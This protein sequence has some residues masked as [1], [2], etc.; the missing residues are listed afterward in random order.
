MV[1]VLVT[2]C[3]EGCL[4]DFDGDFFGE[5]QVELYGEGWVDFDGDG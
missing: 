5:E 4:G 3:G 1:M 2:F